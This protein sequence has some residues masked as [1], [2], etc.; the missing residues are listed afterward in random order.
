MEDTADSEDIQE[1]AAE[2]SKADTSSDTAAD[3]IESTNS[4][5][6]E[7]AASDNVQTADSSDDTGKLNETFWWDDAWCYHS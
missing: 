2:V 5:N 1:E 4:D 3:S 7:V 6:G